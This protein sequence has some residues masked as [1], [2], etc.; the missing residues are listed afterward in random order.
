MLGMQS[1]KNSDQMSRLPILPE[2]RRGIDKRYAAATWHL[3]VIPELPAAVF[4]V[5][6]RNTQDGSIESNA[7]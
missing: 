5:Q 7:Q 6:K 2:Q 3:R 1:S 4:L